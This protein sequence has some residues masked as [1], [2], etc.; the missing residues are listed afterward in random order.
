MT[1][2]EIEL[3]RL[4]EAEADIRAKIREVETKVIDEKSRSPDRARQYTTVDGSVGLQPIRGSVMAEREA[5]FDPSPRR[6]RRGDSE[7]PNTFTG[8]VLCRDEFGSISP[9]RE[10]TDSTS[11][12]KASPVNPTTQKQTRAGLWDQG[13]GAKTPQNSVPS[14]HKRTYRSYGDTERAVPP[15]F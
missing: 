7:I 12:L 5:S 4:R 11:P 3:T 10:Y 8:K 13:K 1:A 6:T 9:K 2:A 15:P 14:A